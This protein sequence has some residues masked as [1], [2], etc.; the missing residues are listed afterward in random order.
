M[1]SAFSASSQKPRLLNTAQRVL[2]SPQP[3]AGLA[4]ADRL[5]H[6]AAV[7]ASSSSMTQC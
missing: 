2:A 3:A 6:R 1:S 5:V 4:R 7:G